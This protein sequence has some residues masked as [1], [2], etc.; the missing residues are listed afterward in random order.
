YKVPVYG[1]TPQFV[2]GRPIHHFSISPDGTQMAFYRRV[3]EEN[4]QYLDI[5][6]ITAPD[7]CRSETRLADGQGFKIWGSAPDWSPDGLKL[8]AATIRRDTPTS[9]PREFLSAIDIPTGAMREIPS[10]AW[11]AVH[12]AFWS[13]DG[14]GVFSMVRENRG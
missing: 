14:N 2:T 7:D 8:L 10:P 1:G 5:C 12:Q 13:R 11:E 9:K 4:A 6:G 3:P